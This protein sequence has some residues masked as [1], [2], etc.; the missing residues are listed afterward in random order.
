M[1]VHFLT[2]SMVVIIYNNYYMH[3]FI[4]VHFLTNILFCFPA[5]QC[6]PDSCK[7]TPASVAYHCLL[8]GGKGGGGRREEDE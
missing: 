3:I 1:Y 7:C 4:Y 6:I 5:E 8:T 2:H